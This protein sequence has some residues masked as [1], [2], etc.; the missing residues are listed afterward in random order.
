MLCGGFTALDA[1][2]KDD[3]AGP[4]PHTQRSPAHYGS[5][6]YLLG[7]T[8]EAATAVIVDRIGIGRVVLPVLTSLAAQRPDSSHCGHRARIGLDARPRPHRLVR[9]PDA[10]RDAA[11]VAAAHGPIGREHSFDL[12]IQF[13]E[14]ATR[15]VSLTRF[16]RRDAEGSH[17]QHVDGRAFPCLTARAPR[18]ADH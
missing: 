15:R 1:P 16:V 14:S 11:A 9:K 8:K 13:V 18:R 3:M 4:E 6:W 5:G 10:R 2:V 7:E 12:T 17:G